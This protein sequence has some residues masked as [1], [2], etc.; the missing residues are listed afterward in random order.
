M[1]TNSRVPLFPAAIE[2]EVAGTKTGAQTV[3][4]PLVCLVAIPMRKARQSPAGKQLSCHHTHTN[5]HTNHIL[6]TY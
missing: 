4:A 3:T 5:T 1:A 6:I 2:A